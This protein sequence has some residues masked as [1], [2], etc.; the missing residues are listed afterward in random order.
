MPA[1]PI[2][3]RPSQGSG[4][5]AST[6]EASSASRACRVASWIEKRT[7]NAQ[8]AATHTAPRA[9]RGAGTNISALTQNM[10]SS[11]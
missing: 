2:Q 3:F 9:S 4:T 5:R 6:A 8:N 11:A 7:W 10:P 1:A